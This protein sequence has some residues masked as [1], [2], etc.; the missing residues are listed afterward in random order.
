M[1]VSSKCYVARPQEEGRHAVN[2]FRK[3]VTMKMTVENS[4]R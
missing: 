1:R 3:V 2:K 4:K